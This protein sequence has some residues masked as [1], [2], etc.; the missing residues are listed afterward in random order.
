M[1]EDLKTGSKL[2][3]LKQ[4]TRA[5]SEEKVVAAFIARDAQDT[6]KKP[7]VALCEEKG[8]P[9]EWVDTMVHLG[10]VCGIDL[11]AAVAVLLS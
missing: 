9:V 4:S 7:F 1:L 3:G 11:G 8:V 6:V 2:V 10:K 5:V